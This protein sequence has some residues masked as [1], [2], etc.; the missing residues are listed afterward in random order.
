[1]SKTTEIFFVFLGEKF[2]SYAKA[3][4]QLAIETSGLD[5][6]LIGNKKLQKSISGLP[7][8]F[9]AIEDFYS[10]KKF[11]LAASH[12]WA[13]H[14]FRGGLWLKSLER[15]FVINQ[16]METFGY[17]KIL[18]AELDQLIFRA[19]ELVKHLDSLDDFGIFVPFHTEHFAVA[20]I[21]Y[22]NDATALDSL[23]NYAAGDSLYPNEMYLIADWARR[24]PNKI[25]ELPTS[26]S[27][28][29]N[30]H[31]SIVPGAKLLSLMESGGL[32]DAAQ[33]G[34]WVAGIDSKN[35]DI[36]TNP[37]NK[38]VDIHNNYLLS[39]Q[40]LESINF[41][42][43]ASGALRLEFD[44]FESATNLFNLHVHS[45]IHSSILKG[46]VSLPKLFEVANAKNASRLHGMRR[47]QISGWIES[48]LS[49]IVTNPEAVISLL[50]S[51]IN[52]LVGKRSSSRPF[53]SGDS[54]RAIAD[55]V[56]ESGSTFKHFDVS[57]GDIIFCQSELLEELR[58]RVLSQVDF[59]IVLILG[60]SDRNISKGLIS[61]LSL[62]SG[63][64]VFAQNLL[65]P[66]EGVH[67]LP[68]GLENRWRASNGRILPFYFLRHTRRSRVSRVVWGFSIATNPVERTKAALALLKASCA[69]HLGMISSSQHRHQLRSSQFVASPPGN[70]ID[71]HRT[72]EAMYLGCIPVLVDSYLSRYYKS[73]GLPVWVVD[74]YAELTN[75]TESDLNLKYNQ[76]I[77]ESN[78][79]ELWFDLW[80]MKVE[81]A[82]QHALRAHLD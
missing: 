7:I 11:L 79:T 65:E 60:N 2:P 62:K 53:V 8:R 50:F 74:S 42:L 15:L 57:V 12:V 82:S 26:A 45:K 22:V 1:M 81:T 33:V 77:S 31:H 61:E 54:F 76:I 5:V 34:Q 52:T 46:K 25:Y 19:D 35:V 38:F 69:Q 18:H 59:P 39:R 16:Y 64:T 51:K 14:K 3:S 44:G 21:L 24:N 68:I 80:R 49:R 66:I 17:S 47:M 10:S 75:L 72:W 63:S 13:D 20:S 56:W 9:V 32:V 58:L 29:A 23:L 73:I 4:L 70:G 55:F 43:E 28:L 48:K 36:K 37:T 27:Y 67:P 40:D 71:T 6:C 78:E 30:R 41:S